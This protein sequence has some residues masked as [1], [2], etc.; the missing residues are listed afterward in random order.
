MKRK[1]ENLV[2]EAITKIDEHLNAIKEIEEK[3]IELFDGFVGNVTKDVAIREV[4]QICTKHPLWPK[5]ENGSPVG[6][7]SARNTPPGILYNR[8]ST[9]CR[10]YGETDANGVLTLNSKKGIKDHLKYK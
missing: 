7:K 9:Y 5:N 8:F 2:F 3:T 6:E 1:R 10:T 4:K